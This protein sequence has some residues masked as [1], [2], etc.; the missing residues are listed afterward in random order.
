MMT[1][2]SVVLYYSRYRVH[3][4]ADRTC[5]QYQTAVADQRMPR[6]IY[7][8]S[9]N[10]Q[11]DNSNLCTWQA[12]KLSEVAGLSVC[13]NAIRF[14]HFTETKFTHLVEIGMSSTQSI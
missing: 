8:K 13:G 7:I 1:I 12:R 4:T 9:D 6:A 5:K 3:L 14:N 2:S 10:Y 11:S